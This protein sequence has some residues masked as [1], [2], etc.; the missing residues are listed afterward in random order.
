MKTL[1]SQRWF[2]LSLID[3][4]NVE[5]GN[6]DWLYQYRRRALVLGYMNMESE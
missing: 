4:I 2:L 6:C 5:M 3:Y 1:A